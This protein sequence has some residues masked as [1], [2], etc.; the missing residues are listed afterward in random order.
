MIGA[1]AGA[2]AQTAPVAST[3]AWPDVKARFV[4][5]NPTLQAGQIGIDE[6]KAGEVTA[7]LR[8]N[9]QLSLTLDQIGHNDDGK[10]L[11]D[12]NPTSVLSYL[13]ERDG[14]RELRRDSAQG[15]TA[16][17][18]SDQADLTR[19][20]LFTLRSDF[21]QILQAKAFMALAQDNLASYDQVLTLSR[22]RLTAGDIAQMDFDRLALQR[23]NYESDVQTATVNLRSAKIHLLAL[24][25]DRTTSAEQFDVSGSFDFSVS[26][27]PLADLRQL[28]LQTRPDLRSA[29]AAVDKAQTDHRLALAN[30]AVDPTFA[31]DAGFP[32]VS[33]AWNSYSPPL[34][35]YVGVG[36]SIPLRIFDKN[37]GEKLRTELDVS[38]NQKLVD[39]AQVQVFA[40]VDSAYAALV[41][42]I[43]LLQPYR[44]QYLDQATRVRD[45]VSFSYQRGGVS[46]VDFLQ[47]QSEYRAIQIA[48]VNLVGTYLNNVNQLNLAIGQEA[49]Q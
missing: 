13:H 31:I 5:T 19:T 3:M 35:E 28:A 30:G 43:A 22:E 7:F 2:Y 41:S 37:Q 39:A 44:N 23:V 4:A 17:A 25:N 24:L 10:P 6:S 49:I 8:P 32:A 38:R 40:D 11:A 36:V 45:A 9:P 21:V 16:I 20:L 47:S 46:L 42:T 29:L 33:Q 18:V 48:Y 14:K 34:R 27:Q 15:A 1:A 26:T 12:A